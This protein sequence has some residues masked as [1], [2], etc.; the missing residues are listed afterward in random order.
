MMIDEN[1]IGL[2]GLKQSVSSKKIINTLVYYLFCLKRIK[3]LTKQEKNQ[4]NLAQHNPAAFFEEIK[5][6][7]LAYQIGICDFAQSFSDRIKLRMIDDDPSTI[8]DLQIA[9]TIDD[10]DN[11]LFENSIASLPNHTTCFTRYDSGVGT[12]LSEKLV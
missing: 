11:N 12:D 3:K 5:T 2:N 8:L 7:L 1:E 4:S 9:K 10:A 6:R